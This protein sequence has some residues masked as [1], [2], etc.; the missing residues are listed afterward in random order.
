M[1]GSLMLRIEHGSLRSLILSLSCV[2]Y[3]TALWSVVV[4]GARRVQVCVVQ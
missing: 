1:N 3:A 2:R 4:V